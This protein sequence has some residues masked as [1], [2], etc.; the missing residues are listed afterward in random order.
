MTTA[1]QPPNL[2][3]GEP[4]DVVRAY[5]GKVNHG[6]GCDACMDGRARLQACGLS[7][8]FKEADCSADVHRER[9]AACF[10]EPVS[11]D[12]DLTMGLLL[13]FVGL[14]GLVAYFWS[15]M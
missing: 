1:P 11:P 14:V 8:N 2:P 10:S 9:T 5:Q 3:R 6:N 13:T 4:I 12:L 7:A 15:K